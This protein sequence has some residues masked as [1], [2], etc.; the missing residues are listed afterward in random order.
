MEEIRA[1]VQIEGIV[2]GVGFRPFV[3]GLALEHD[4]KGWVLNDEKGV[5]IEIE[6]EKNRVNGFLSG[7][8]VPPPIATIE[9]TAV[10]Y[11]S[12]VG[13]DGFEIKNSQQGED[14]R[15]LV[16]PDIATCKDCLNELFDPHDRR[17]HYPFIN[18][19]N[20]GPRFTIIED[21]P[22]DRES[23]TMAPFSMCPICSREYHDPLNRRFHAQPNACPEC[24]PALKLFTNLG[25][26][27]TTHDPIT[28]VMPVMQQGRRSSPASGREN[29]GRTNPLH[30]CAGI[31]R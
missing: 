4:L 3:Y 1:C 25:K 28:E 15:A 26:E 9:K 7:L 2:Q 27:I 11:L 18:C 22:Y 12:P 14:R 20:C 19:T 6:G 16:S 8:S 23:T 10:Q 21:I 13:Y 31:W 30:S 29:T 5:T 24:G 17:F